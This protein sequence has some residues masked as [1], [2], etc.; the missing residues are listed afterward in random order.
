MGRDAERSALYTLT[1]GAGRRLSASVAFCWVRGR[2][3]DVCAD[4]AGR[5]D[6]PR[7]IDAA[8]DARSRVANVGNTNRSN[9]IV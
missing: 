8:P 4:G 2:T 1:S 3:S 6:N 7:I 5:S 9:I